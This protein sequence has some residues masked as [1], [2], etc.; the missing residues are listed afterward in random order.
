MRMSMRPAAHPQEDQG[1]L[2]C[3]VRRQNIVKKK[4]LDD[5]DGKDGGTSS[6][7]TMEE[8]DEDND[9][10]LHASAWWYPRFIASLAHVCRPKIMIY[11]YIYM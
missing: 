6:R 11:I 7:I 9:D 1:A 10:G 2:V 3:H 5:H 4:A 8:N